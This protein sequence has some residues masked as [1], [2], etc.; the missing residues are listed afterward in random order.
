MTAWT[1]CQKARL[2]RGECRLELGKLT[3]LLFRN[4]RNVQTKHDKAF[5]QFFWRASVLSASQ[6]LFD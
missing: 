1:I 5:T 3:L 6:P 2:L 4:F